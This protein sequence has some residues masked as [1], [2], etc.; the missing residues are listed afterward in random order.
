MFVSSSSE[1]EYNS[2]KDDDIEQ[3]FVRLPTTPEVLTQAQEEHKTQ[4]KA[5]KEANTENEK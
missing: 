3:H 5:V 2:K 4:R 1:E